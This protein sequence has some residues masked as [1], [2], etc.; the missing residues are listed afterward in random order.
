LLLTSFIASV[1]VCI[2]ANVEW[3]TSLFIRQ[4][5]NKQNKEVLYRNLRKQRKLNY[6]NLTKYYRLLQSLQK[7]LTVEL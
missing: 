7:P 5:E 2:C 4:V 6:K 1:F 3:N